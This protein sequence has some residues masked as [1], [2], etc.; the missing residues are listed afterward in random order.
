MLE[1]N[2]DQYNY[3]EEF[4]VSPINIKYG[5]NKKLK[6]KNSYKDS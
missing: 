6:N 3:E 4:D 5:K 1:Q 2:Y